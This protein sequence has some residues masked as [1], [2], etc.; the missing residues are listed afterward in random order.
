M[1]NS[2]DK[3]KKLKFLGLPWNSMDFLV[4]LWKFNVFTF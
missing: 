2:G 4:I 3:I 1:E